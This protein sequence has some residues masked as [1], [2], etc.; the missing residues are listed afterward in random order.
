MRLE[1]GR[2]AS[3]I[4]VAAIGIATVLCGCGG[5]GGG[6]FRPNIG[7]LVGFAGWDSLSPTTCRGYVGSYFANAENVRVELW[8]AT[9]G[10]ERSTELYLGGVDEY[11]GSLTPF[12]APPQMTNGEPR[13]PRVGR[14][15]WNPGESGGPPRA[16]RF[17]LYANWCWTAPDSLRLSI[18]NFG[19]WAYGVVVTLE[20]RDGVRDFSPPLGHIAA[21][22]LP[23]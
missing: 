2:P 16:P 9:D 22:G 13:Y 18:E 1:P 23:P 3:C 7:P 4:A 15:R 6:S 21:A 5:A 17:P 8:Y 19:G 20:N 14:I 11:P 12:Y 10:N